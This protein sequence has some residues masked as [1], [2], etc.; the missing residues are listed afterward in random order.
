MKIAVLGA[1]AMGMLIGGMLSTANDVLLVDVSTDTVNKINENGVIIHES[2]GSLIK[3]NPRAATNT[4]GLKPVDLI[5]VFVKAMYSRTALESNKH[6]IGESTYIMTL[7]NG[8]GH[9][10]VLNEF[11]DNSHVIIGTTQHNSSV[12]A[13]GEVHHGGS[14]HTYIG[15]L[16]EDVSRLKPIEDAFNSAK[17]AASIDANVKKLIWS[18]MFT[19]V[20]A[21]ALTGAL[22]CTLGFIASNKHA[23][24]MC[25]V[26]VKEA[27]EVAAGDNLEFD[28][29]EQL[30]AVRKVCQGAPNGF[31][32]IYS[33]LA[34]GRKTEVDTISGSVVKASLRN[35]V[36]APSHNFIVN[37]IHAMEDNFDTKKEQ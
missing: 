2:D 8:A 19:N 13:L 7:Q 27:V 12:I 1:G 20:S 15:S 33:D 28:Y 9:E 3:V 22:Q 4:L 37:I 35:K 6:L 29:A 10:E 34:A 17:L 21:S 11:V 14:G 24:E 25:K 32:S 26:L 36:P 23:W 31:T 30:E 16:T 18:K 5:I